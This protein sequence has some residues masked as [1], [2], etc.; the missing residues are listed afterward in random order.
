MAS[1]CLAPLS[2]KSM[3]RE[4]PDLARFNVMALPVHETKGTGH[5][6]KD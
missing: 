4:M 6:T 3:A 2:A 1:A 5:E